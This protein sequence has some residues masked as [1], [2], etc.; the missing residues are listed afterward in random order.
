[1]KWNI[2]FNE[3]KVRGFNV[4][5][6]VV[7]MNEVDQNGKKVR[8]QLEIDFVCNKGSK[9]YYIQSAFALAE[10]KKME[11]EQRPLINTG[12]GFKKVIITKD[13]LAPLYNEEGVLVMSIYD[14]LLDPDSL[15]F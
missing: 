13:A 2:V 11:Q 3:L 8:K 4:D 1:M 7:V 14:F 6:G 10:Q 12:D 15:D 5:V 9:K